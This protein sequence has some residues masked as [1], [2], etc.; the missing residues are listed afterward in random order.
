[1]VGLESVAGS[2]GGGLAGSVAPEDV[3]AD[4]GGMMR[5]AGVVTTGLLC[6]MPTWRMVPS[7]TSSSS[8]PGPR[9]GP[10]AISARAWPLLLVTRVPVV[11]GGDRRGAGGGAVG[12]G[13]I[14]GVEGEGFEGQ[15]LA[16]SGVG[17]VGG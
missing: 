12:E 11:E 8:S 2:A 17:A 14:Q 6:W 5:V 9:R 4:G 10:A 16:V 3:V 13:G 1:M 15:R 7:Q